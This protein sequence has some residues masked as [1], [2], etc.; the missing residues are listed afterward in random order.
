MVG[1]VNEEWPTHVGRE[2][3]RL[4]ADY[5]RLVRFNA[6]KWHRVSTITD[7]GERLALAVDLWDRRPRM[8]DPKQ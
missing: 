8:F 2:L 5:N 3:E 4:R 7:D 1:G 6:S